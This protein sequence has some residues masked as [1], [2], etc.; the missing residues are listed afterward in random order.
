MSYATSQDFIDAFGL[1]EAIMLTNLD[2][3]S[4]TIPNLIPLDK[5]LHDASAFIDTYVGSR[6]LLPLT[7]VSTVVNRY[8]LDIARYMLDRIRSR[9]DVRLRYEDA[10]KFLTLVAKGQVSIG[11]D[12]L[13]GGNVASIAGDV[14]V[15]GARSYAEPRLNLHGYGGRW[16]GGQ[17]P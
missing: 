15:A 7:A 4:A 11:A 16:D 8:C 2:D 9:E 3:P 1:Q 13:T 10:I 5:A 6:Y 14:T 17:Y 12:L